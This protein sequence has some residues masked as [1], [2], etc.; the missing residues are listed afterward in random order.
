MF[1]ATVIPLPVYANV[2][3]TENLAYRVE[4]KNAS[5]VTASFNLNLGLTDPAVN[6][7]DTLSKPVTIT[8][9][10]TNVTLDLSSK[11]YMFPV[12][13]KYL[14]TLNFDG[15]ASDLT[16]LRFIT[17]APGARLDVSKSL[18]PNVLPPGND[19]KVRINIRLKGGVS[20]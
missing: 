12:S 1:S 20:Q 13:G 8:Q 9:D 2:H 16:T 18:T 14:S 17:V 6:T 11:A 15:I 3:T 5:N 7:V 10:Q 4:L 19:Q